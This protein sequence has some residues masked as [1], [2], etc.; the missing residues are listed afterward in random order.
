MK[1]PDCETCL[2]TKIY[3]LFSW[4]TPRLP[5]DVLSLQVRRRVK[6]P[7][8]NIRVIFKKEGFPYIRAKNCGWPP[9]VPFVPTALSER[10]RWV[11]GGAWGYI[12]VIRHNLFISFFLDKIKTDTI[13]FFPKFMEFI[14]QSKKDGQTELCFSIHIPIRWTLCWA[15]VSKRSNA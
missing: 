2:P 9:L 13:W 6:K 4:L 7:G 10:H 11:L 3:N 14:P 15:P 5:D 1:R 12:T 8:R